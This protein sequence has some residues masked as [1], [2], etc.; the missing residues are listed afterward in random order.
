MLVCYQVLTAGQGQNPARQASV[1]AGLPH[2]VPA[3]SVNMLCGSGLRSIMMGAQ[4]IKLG[5][6]D[7]VVA[8]GQ[9][10]MSQAHHS[11]NL[12]TGVKMGDAQF[13]DTMISDG[14]TDAFHKYH[15]GITGTTFN[16]SSIKISTF[17][18]IHF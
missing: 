6:S 14:L 4:A 8:G 5:D 18:Y 3:T 2:S 11:A 10:S 1:N 13:V 15:M 17:F 9:E 16:I 7:I 12:R